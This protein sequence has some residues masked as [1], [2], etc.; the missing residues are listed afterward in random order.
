[1]KNHDMDLKK[2]ALRQLIIFLIFTAS[3]IL[4]LQEIQTGSPTPK[5]LKQKNQTM[6][7]PLI[8][9]DLDDTVTEEIESGLEEVKNERIEKKKLY[10]VLNIIDG[11][12]IDVFIDE[13]IK[14]VRLIGINTPETVDPRKK[15]ECFGKEASSKAR[16][17]LLGKE[18]LLEQDETQAEE[19]KYGRLLRYVFLKD[20]TNFNKWMIENG[21]AYEYTYIFPYNY[22]KEFKDAEISAMENNRG[23]WASNACK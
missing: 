22:Q 19:D 14:R 15:V 8:T 18:I 3:F 4:G 1:M 2:F 23:L 12:T 5:N 7:D 16:E 17:M 10:L 9:K 6:T 13:K 20:E 21:Y 11:D